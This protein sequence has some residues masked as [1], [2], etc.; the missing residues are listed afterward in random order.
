MQQLELLVAVA[1]V[2]QLLQPLET[3]ICLINI[4][5]KTTKI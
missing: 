3:S 1:L 5:V 2:L 4:S